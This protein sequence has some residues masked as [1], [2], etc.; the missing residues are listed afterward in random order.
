LGRRWLIA[1]S[2]ESQAWVAFHRAAFPEAERLFGEAL[3]VLRAMGDRVAAPDAMDGLAATLHARSNSR[4]AARLLGQAQAMRQRRRKHVVPA[5]QGWYERLLES[6]REL[7]AA[8]HS[9]PS[10]TSAATG[11]HEFGAVSRRRTSIVSDLS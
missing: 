3:D 2:T 6:V 5:L 10:G 1:A 11:G 7:L 8:R 9:A 4:E